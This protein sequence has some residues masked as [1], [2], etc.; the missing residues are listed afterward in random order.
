M[1]NPKSEKEE[2]SLKTIAISNTVMRTASAPP[3]ISNNEIENPNYEEDC[4]ETVTSEDHVSECG[5]S[6]RTSGTGV[7]NSKDHHFDSKLKKAFQSRESSW[8]M[9]FGVDP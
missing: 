3:A 1:S 4:E 8:R 5:V 9:D 6:S 2:L 7:L